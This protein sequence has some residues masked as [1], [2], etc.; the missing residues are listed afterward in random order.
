MS[1]IS[2]NYKYLSVTVSAINKVAGVCQEM[3]AKTHVSDHG[4][5]DRYWKVG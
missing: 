3:T 2:Q 1:K 5:N 4:K